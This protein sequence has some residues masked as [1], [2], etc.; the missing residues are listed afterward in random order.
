MPWSNTK[1][2][3]GPTIPGNGLIHTKNLIISL[4]RVFSDLPMSSHEGTKDADFMVSLR[5]AS[6]VMIRR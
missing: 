3:F 2:L 6:I 5:H 4:R 1:P